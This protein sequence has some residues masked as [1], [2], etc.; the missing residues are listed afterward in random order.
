MDELSKLYDKYGLPGL[1]FAGVYVLAKA[2]IFGWKNWRGTWISYVSLENKN[3]ELSD[4]IDS[5]AMD[6]NEFKSKVENHL[7]KEASEEILIGQIRQKQDFQDEKMVALKEMI[8]ALQKHQETVFT[9]ISNIKDKM[10]K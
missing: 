1:V 5:I 6:F 8:E 4:K 3:R 9:L 2:G 10:I 7:T